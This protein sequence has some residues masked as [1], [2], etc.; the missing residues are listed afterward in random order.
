[1]TPLQALTQV[2]IPVEGMTCA[3]CQARVQRALTRVPG[4]SDASVNLL[5]HRASVRFD[6]SQVTP[7][8]LVS[9]I[10]AT[11][12]DAHLEA[13]VVDPVAEQE[14]RDEADAREYLGL[15][16]K[17]WVSAAVGIVAMVVSMPLMAPDAH[18]HLGGTVD[19]LMHWMMTTLHPGLVR[20]M[21]WLYAIDRTVLSWALLLTTAGVMAWAG[22][23]F[24][25][26]AWTAGRHGGADMNT[27]VA[28]GTMAAFVYSVVATVA[29]GIFL[30]RGLQPDVYFEAVVLIIALI[31]V[32]RTFEAR[33]KRRTADALRALAGL[34]PRTARVRRD[35]QDV[36][37]P[38]DEVVAGDL[39]VTRPGER[40][41][42]DGQI[43][44]GSSSVDESMLT[45]ES[46][47]VDKK[48][49]ARVIGGTVNGAGTLVYRATTLGAA[50]TLA[51]IVRLMRDAQ[52]T[53]APIQD[54]ADRIS[55]V[56]V[57]VVMALALVT[58]VAWWIVGGDGAVVRGL[59]AAV[60]VLIIAC[61]CA[62]GLA[63]PTAVMV[64]TGKG[65]EA[66][67][68]IKGG[69]ALQRT[70]DVSVVVFDKTGTLTEGKP[71]VTREQWVTDAAD[72]LALVAAVEHRSEHPL[73]AAIV[74]HAKASGIMLPDANDVV[75]HAGRGA[76]GHVNGRAVLVGSRRLLEESDVEVGTL[77][78]TAEQWAG[79]GASL[80]F[81]AIDG[82]PA[83]LIAVADRIKPG[84][85]DAVRD[86]RALGLGVVML[87]GDN[88]TTARAIGAQAGIDD[89]VA[90]VLPEGKVAEIARRQQMGAVVAMV[91]DGINDAPALAQADIGIAMGTGTDVAMA[92]SDVTLVRGQID[93]VALAVRLARRTL[94]T[95][96]QNL[97]WAFVYNV[98]GI[99]VAAGVL[100]PATGLLLSPVIASAAMAFS[101]VSVVGNS[102]RL[103]QLTLDRRTP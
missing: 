21:P 77:A 46:M 87:S 83:G 36:D 53:R 35:G 26:R 86:L 38:I 20:W 67:V 81:A 34:Q 17:A 65:A 47:P 89:V 8:A 90:G 5:A 79:E 72:S 60:T 61:P 71:S 54:L 55:A 24:Y 56:F 45:G 62:M 98:V 23:Q 30:R 41:A 1:M 22:R 9:A 18:G 94:A 64:A 82:R 76:S 102:L 31:L 50:S 63:V 103:R 101:S 49:G 19:P 69:D 37:V 91:G 68:L 78:Q 15:R 16:R 11:G 88:P 7:D 10:Q 57:P 96:R 51:Q 100:Y 32:G 93:G 84:A 6:P 48:A 52:A 14:A 80:V 4:V 99:P 40:L 28:V 97:F 75:A 73:A 39:V 44:D 42:V 2:Q 85:A 74:A 66:G 29:P 13:D 33:A 3:A 58:F 59:A 43:E 27:L 12:Y 92:A 95:M 70:A 25:V